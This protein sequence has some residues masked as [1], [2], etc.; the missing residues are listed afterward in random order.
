MQAAGG[1]P[2]EENGNFMQQF[3]G[4]FSRRIVAEIP[5]QGSDPGPL[6]TILLAILPALA[7][8]L[9]G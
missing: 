7:K 8:P 2:V 5:D 6:D 3:G 1:V 4:I 9:L